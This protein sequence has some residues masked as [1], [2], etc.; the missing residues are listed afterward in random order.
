MEPSEIVD[1][2]VSDTPVNDTSKFNVQKLVKKGTDLAT[3]KFVSFKIEVNEDEYKILSE[4]DM[5]PEH[6]LMRPFIENKKLGNFFPQSNQKPTAEEME[7]NQSPN[8]AADHTH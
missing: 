1:Y 4:P 3:L 6:V 5:W 7:T 8:R 2:I